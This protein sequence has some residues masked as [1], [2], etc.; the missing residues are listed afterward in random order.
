VEIEAIAPAFAAAD[1]ERVLTTRQLAWR[2]FKRHKIA[3][4][5]LIVLLVPGLA[6]WWSL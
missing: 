6:T 5:S 3:I 1:L 2:R 4:A